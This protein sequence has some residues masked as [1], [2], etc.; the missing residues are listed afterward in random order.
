MMR[1]T[2]PYEMLATYNGLANERLYA[3]CMASK[4]YRGV[5]SPFPYG[6]SN[7]PGGREFDQ[8]RSAPGP[9]A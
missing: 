9:D 5:P 3:A 1:L 6:V 7:Y 2:E 8:R 4:G